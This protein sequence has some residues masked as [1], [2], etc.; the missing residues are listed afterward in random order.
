MASEF[1]TIVMKT[2]IWTRILTEPANNKQLGDMNWLAWSQGKWIQ[3][4]HHRINAPSCTE[5]VA[6]PD[7][8]CVLSLV[9]GLIRTTVTSSQGTNSVFLPGRCYSCV[10]KGLQQRRISNDPVLQCAPWEVLVVVTAVLQDVS[11]LLNGIKVEMCCQFIIQ[12][13]IW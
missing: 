3:L 12:A 10:N 4:N 5:G 6:I 9:Q 8:E 7:S 1:P 11:R 13:V 2:L